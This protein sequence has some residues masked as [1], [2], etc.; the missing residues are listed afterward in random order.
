MHKEKMAE[1]ATGFVFLRMNAS[2]RVS[3]QVFSLCLKILASGTHLII[4]HK[5]NVRRKQT[6]K[7][8]YF[9]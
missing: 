6:N 5:R 7:G 3:T 8:E 4:G 9:I 2:A 1:V